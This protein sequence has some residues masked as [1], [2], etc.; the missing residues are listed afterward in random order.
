VR[1]AQGRIRR[2]LTLGNKDA[3]VTEL[4][5]QFLA[6][7]TDKE[8]TEPGGGNNNDVDV[9]AVCIRDRHWLLSLAFVIVVVGWGS[10]NNNHD[11]NGEF[12]I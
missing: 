8:A 12:F 11:S 4:G 3:A 5:Q 7:V 2:G 1:F 9:D 6:T 10:K